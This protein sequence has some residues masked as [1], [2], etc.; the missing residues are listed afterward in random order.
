MVAILLCGS[1]EPWAL[2]VFA[3]L[4]GLTAL[5]AAPRLAVS[6]RLTLPLL[7]GLLLC[8][9]AFL[10]ASWFPLPEW[11]II[12]QRDFG[13]SMA[14]T[15]SP[16]PW[17]TFESWV[18]LAVSAA[19][20]FFCLGRGFSEAERR[21]AL[22]IIT[23]FMAV[24][25]CVAMVVNVLKVDI[26]FWRGV[27]KEWFFGPFPNRNNFSGLLAIGVL[28]GLAITY[29]AFRCRQRYWWGYLV[30]IAPMFVA[31]L[32]NSSRMG[33]IALFIGVGTWMFTASL[34]RQS[35]QRAAIFLA[36]LVVAAAAAMLFGG[37]LMTRFTGGEEGVVATLA[38][39]ARWQ[40]FQDATDLTISSPAFGIGLGNFEPIFAMTRTG[41]ELN[42]RAIH[43]ENDWLWFGAETGLFCLVLAVI[44]TWLLVS[45]FGLRQKLEGQAVRDKRIRSAAGIGVLLM[46][47]EGLVNT[48]MHAPGFFAF[49]SLLAGLALAP[50]APAPVSLLPRRA[51]ALITLLCGMAWLASASGNLSLLGNSHYRLLARQ[52]AALSAQGDLSGALE[53]WDR[54]ASIKPLQWNVYFERAVLKLRLG[55]PHGEALWDFSCWRRLERS[56]ANFC[57]YEFDL[58]LDYNPVYGVAAL[59][60]A[61][62]RDPASASTFFAHRTWRVE[63]YP[64]LRPHFFAIAASDPK[65]TLAYLQYASPTEFNW[66][67]SALLGQHPTLSIFTPE[68]KLR[69]FQIWAE[70]GDVPKLLQMMEDNP[71]WRQDA[72]I[73]LATQKAKGGDFQA[74]YNLAMG[75]VRVP[76]KLGSASVTQDD[77]PDLA[78]K[79]DRSPT[80]IPQG[81]KLYEAQRRFSR[82]A[83][84]SATLD[85]LAQLPTIPSRV[86]FERADLCAEKSDYFSAW[87]Q[88][89]EYYKRTHSEQVA[90]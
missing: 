17:I 79:F 2:G 18:T 19:W 44:F 74:A 30:A 28:L 54:A 67:L 4:V 24:L 84:A 82:S 39:D 41:G 65:L 73:V 64:A 76:P 29:D 70:K 9:G 13:I 15:R 33:V 86:Y 59:R 6:R 60:E 68:E 83:E 89:F 21:R 34:S 22:R 25:A 90:K 10:P 49:A 40:M 32:A 8:L 61:M 52:A 87:E 47:L 62:R 37:Q 53:T 78:K 20:L 7:A 58:W 27:S 85:R 23:G 51:L 14:A 45:S 12:L 31:V 72:W 77:L 69:T 36:L 75:R 50:S 71:E 57:A 5:V 81:F 11:R 43:P 35:V 42:S 38:K 26:P 48:P 56:N 80:D 1:K 16:Q 55:R 66:L 88:I 63:A 3:S 46:G